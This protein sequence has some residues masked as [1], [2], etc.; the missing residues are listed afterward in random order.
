M[1][2]QFYSMENVVHNNKIIEYS[3]TSLCAIGGIVSGILGFTGL[4]GLVAYIAIYFVVS[5]GLI[6]KMNWRV[7]QYAAVKGG[8]PMFLI[9]GAGDK[10]GTPPHYHPMYE[11]DCA[12]RAR[13]KEK[14]C[15]EGNVPIAVQRKEEL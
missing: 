11:L 14:A 1:D 6:L 7:S 10:L 5:L 13:K 8:V 2:R 12:K 3:R 9:G 15:R 4:Q